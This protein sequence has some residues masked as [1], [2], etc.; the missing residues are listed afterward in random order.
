MGLSRFFKSPRSRGNCSLRNVS[1]LKSKLFPL[2]SLLLFAIVPVS[3]QDQGASSE[4]KAIRGTVINSV[5]QEPIPRALV[6][7]T[8]ER[9][10]T[11]TDSS[12]HFE[13]TIPK[14][15]N[16]ASTPVN[17]VFISAGLSHR[18]EVWLNA[19][20]PGFFNNQ[21]R[22][23]PS[24]V[25]KDNIISLI[26]EAIIKGHISLSTGDPA[27][28]VSVQIYSHQVANGFFRWTQGAVTRTDSAGEFRFAEL[29]GGNYK[30]ATHEFMDADPQAA[31][32]GD[33][34][35]IFP[36]SYFPGGSDFASGADIDLQAGQTA[37]AN[38]TL[39]LQR[40]Y[41][42]RIPVAG[43][44][45]NVPLLVTL[46]GPH[47][48]GFDLGYN[49]SERRIEGSL[50][51][52]TYIVEVICGGPS[53]SAASV[54]I[55]VQGA[56]TDGPVLALAHFATIPVVVK[57]EFNN[58][59]WNGSVFMGV[60]GR[61]FAI[62]GPRRYLNIS[63]ETVDD[64]SAF[65]GGA[66][67]PPTGPNDV[68]MELDNLAPGKYWINVNTSRGYVASATSGST[69]LLHEP[70]KVVSGANSPIEV[71]LRDDAA[72]LDGNIAKSSG[73][74]AVIAPGT[75]VYVVPLPDSSGQFQQTGISPDGKFELQNLPPGSYRVLAFATSQ[76][77]L[78]Y[79]DVES[80]KAWEGKGQVVRL[81]AGQKTSVQIPLV[82]PGN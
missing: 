24:V 65:R 52:G 11:L 78:P 81:T 74:Q 8:N 9:F 27:A 48:P 51:N 54:T 71:T 53:Q 15:Q 7:S 45:A 61:T 67:R 49:A 44:D 18:N 33:E 47:G 19:R 23:L 64:F 13:F 40:Y 72:S 3:S 25:D 28:G 66:I 68:G 6:T 21:E 31:V 69:D 39:T 32:S 5:T 79:R 20:K 77:A 14:A 63:V 80:M 17:G 42:I 76:K 43:N 62:N 41:P 50:P 4:A 70:L 73:Q 30:I 59:V 75:T 26:P 36:P 1:F 16:D 12:G 35:P 60:G 55:T 37:E 58:K 38:L 2:L 34:R 10:A 56:P 29:V 22:Y 57:E 82:E 46:K